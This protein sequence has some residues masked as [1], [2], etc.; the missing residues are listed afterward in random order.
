MHSVCTQPLPEICKNVEPL[1]ESICREESPPGETT[2]GLTTQSLI[3][4]KH[5]EAKTA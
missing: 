3:L 5:E 4:R 1:L 2:D